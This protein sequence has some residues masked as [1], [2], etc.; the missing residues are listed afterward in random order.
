[1]SGKHHK[2]SSR[3]VVWRGEVVIP[4]KMNLQS[5]ITKRNDKKKVNNQEIN[6][7]YIS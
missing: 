5:K 3:E 1:M 6:S 2:I 7:F 4:A